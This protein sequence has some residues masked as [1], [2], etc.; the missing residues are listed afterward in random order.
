MILWTFLV[1]IG[2][3]VGL[4][5]LAALAYVIWRLRERYQRWKRNRGKPKKPWLAKMHHDGCD[6]C[7]QRALQKELVNE[8]KDHAT[9][10]DPAQPLSN[11]DVSNQATV[12]I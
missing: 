2:I 10:A 7:K 11:N 6:V 8:A 4:V 3:G 9:S 5:L 12:E 1:F